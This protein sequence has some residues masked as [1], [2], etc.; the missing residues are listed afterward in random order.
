MYGPSFRALPCRSPSRIA[1]RLT[2][3]LADDGFRDDLR[4]A[5]VQYGR[6][7]RLFS[8]GLAAPLLPAAHLHVT[9]RR[10]GLGAQWTGGLREAARR[11][12]DEL[13][14]AVAA[15]LAGPGLDA[16]TVTMEDSGPGGEHALL[17]EGVSAHGRWSRR[18]AFDPPDTGAMHPVSAQILA[19][20]RRETEPLRF[21]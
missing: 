6:R 16:T 20:L 11:H 21:D 19:A 14:S 4:A 2:Q 18:I 8:N 7:I 13:N 10:P 5:A 3:A 1:E 12:P 17:A 15:A 9:V